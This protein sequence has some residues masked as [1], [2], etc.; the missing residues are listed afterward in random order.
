MSLAQ[1]SPS[2]FILNFKSTSILIN[3]KITCSLFAVSVK[4]RALARGRA[5]MNSDNKATNKHTKDKYQLL[6]FCIMMDGPIFPEEPPGPHKRR[7]PSMS[8]PALGL[9]GREGLE[10]RARKK[11]EN[12]SR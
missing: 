4:V 12:N 8:D 9:S 6:K 1:L 5:H 10:T 7:G 2:L 11:H 3:K